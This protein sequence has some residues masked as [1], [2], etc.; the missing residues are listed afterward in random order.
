MRL[1]PKIRVTAQEAYNLSD[2]APETA[3]NLQYEW[4]RH[5]EA[6]PGENFYIITE[7]GQVW[8]ISPDAEG[9]SLIATPVV[10]RFEFG[11][12]SAVYP[13]AN[14]WSELQSDMGER[15]SL[16]PP[17]TEEEGVVGQASMKVVARLIRE[18]EEKN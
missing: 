5:Q 9:E 1:Y 18:F 14:A 4:I 8:T 16:W 17:R 6:A 11:E 7:Q 2:T 12:D 15:F 13:G 10:Q 3:N